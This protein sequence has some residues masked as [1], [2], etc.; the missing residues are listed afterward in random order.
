MTDNSAALRRARAADSEARLARCESVLRAMVA[1]GDPV[2]VAEVTRRAGVGEKFPFRHP[3]LMAKI[4]EA[5]RAAVRRT[6]PDLDAALAVERDFWKQRTHAVQRRLDEAVKRIAE[7]E[8]QRVAEER[9][10]IVP[11]HETQA[12]RARVAQLE[13]AIKTL[14][15][16]A[17]HGDRDVE[18][19]R[20]LNRDL[21]REN[22]RLREA[23]SGTG[24]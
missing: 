9:G 22:T 7:L 16:R 6:A 4:D 14:E 17:T 13:A 10:L 1:A 2:T 8:G 20:K 3:V 15:A 21:V 24:T 5:K 19:V 12:L 23:A 11:Q 18:A